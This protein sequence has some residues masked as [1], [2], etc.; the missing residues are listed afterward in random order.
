M[1]LRIEQVGEERCTLGEGLWWDARGQALY[2][3]DVVG[4][5]VWRRDF[6]AD[7]AG[8]ADG[9]YREW[10]MPDVVSSVILSEGGGAIVTLS[11]GFYVVDLDAAGALDGASAPASACERIGAEIEA[12]MD[13]RFNDAK[14][15]RQGRFV[16]GTMDNRIR[17]PLGSIY[18]LAAGGGGEPRVL[19]RG[20]ICSNGPC[21]SLDGRTFYFTDSMRRT[22]YAYDY[23]I[24]TGA[25]A[26]RRVLTDFAALGI[27]CAPD[28]C[29][30]DAEGFLWS[31]LCLAG[32][33]AR[34]APSGKI[35]RLIDMP[36]KYV[37]SVMFGGASLDVLFVTSLNLPLRKQPPTE[38]NA[39]ALFAV[40]GLGV[41][42]V[43]EPRVRN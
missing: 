33:V 19:D 13:T 39:G 28:G 22:I 35:E 16:A 37:T 23:D 15:D 40:R 38:P 1:K 21:W 2:G 32:Q 43:E 26:N 42:G 7:E 12:G 3:V 17:E 10:P 18:Q 5:K 34:I 14:A 29:T 9:A 24:E 20:M 41:R 25:S 30:V 36:V 11:H 8:G 4:R 6:G 27:D 31:A